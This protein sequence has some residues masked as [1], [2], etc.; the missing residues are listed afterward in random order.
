MVFRKALQAFALYRH[1]AA[2]LQAVG[3]GVAV[4]GGEG[5]AGAVLDGA[6]AVAAAGALGV[7]VDDVA[8]DANNV[9]TTAVVA[10]QSVGFVRYGGMLPAIDND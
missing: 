3:Y 4:G 8:I 5:V 2:H 6:H 7:F 9:G 1:Q 10:V